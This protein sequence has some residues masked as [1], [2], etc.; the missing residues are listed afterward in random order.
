MRILLW[1]NQP[2]QAGSW[3]IAFLSH[4]NITH[5]GFQRSNGKVHELSPPGVHD[6]DLTDEERPY[7]HAFRLYGVTPQMEG[8]LERLFDLN[9]AAGIAYSYEDLFKYLFNVPMDGDQESF[10][11]RYVFH[12]LGMCRCP[13][14]LVRCSENVAIPFAFWISPLLIEEPL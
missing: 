13:M 6:R 14:P 7:V 10:C 4:G 2:G 11:T 5:G 1:A 8:Q 3:A 12:C 9:I